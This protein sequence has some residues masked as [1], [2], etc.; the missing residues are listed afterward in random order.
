MSQPETI[1]PTEVGTTNGYDRR[2]KSQVAKGR[3]E[4]MTVT[5]SLRPGVPREWVTMGRGRRR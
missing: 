3:P 5:V 4:S 2:F 1:E